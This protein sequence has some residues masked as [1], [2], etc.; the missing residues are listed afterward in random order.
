MNLWHSLILGLVEGVTEFLPISSTGHLIL[1]TRLLGLDSTEFVKSFE[2]IIQLGAILAVVVLYWRTL[3][4][5]WAIM[6][7]LAVAFLPTAVIGLAFYSLVKQYLL[8]SQAVVLWAMLLGGVALII[9]EL[10]HREPERGPDELVRLPYRKAFM[11]GLYQTIAIIPGVSRSAAT[12]V[13]GLASGLSRRAAVEFSFL[14]AAPTMAA[15]TGLD[16]LKNAGSFGAA[17]AGILAVGFIVSF[18]VA[19][20]SIKF[21]LS[22]IKQN[23]FVVFGIYRILAAAVFYFLIF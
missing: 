1:T 14:L 2:I 16:L 19:L 6:K 15:A 7:R 3:F 13:G 22:F 21:L 23:S 18:L 5:N 4:V 11:L 9:F 12:I 8:S 20:G 17:Q 10:I